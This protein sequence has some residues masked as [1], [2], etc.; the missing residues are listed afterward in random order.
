M[1]ELVIFVF[2]KLIPRSLIYMSMQIS[3]AMHHYYLPGIYLYQS[4]F[5]LMSHFNIDSFVE[6]TVCLKL[7]VTSEISC[8]SPLKIFEK[9]SGKYALWKTRVH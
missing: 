4:T 2:L 6:Q 8:A 9:A 7:Y 3:T 5:Y 1:V